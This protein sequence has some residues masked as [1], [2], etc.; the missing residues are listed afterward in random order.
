MTGKVRFMLSER[1]LR[2]KWRLLFAL[3]HFSDVEAKT[4]EQ[5]L[6]GAGT[7]E[8]AYALAAH[9]WFLWQLS[10]KSTSPPSSGCLEAADIQVRRRS[11]H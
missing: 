7:A 2:T 1:V 9:R 6:G 8:G 5:S 3:S 11:L 10:P 4:E